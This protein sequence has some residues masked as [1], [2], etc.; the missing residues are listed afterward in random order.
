[1][2]DSSRNSGSALGRGAGVWLAVGAFA[3]VFVLWQWS[4]S[5]AILYP[6]RLL[7][8]FVHEAGHGLAAIVSG[9]RF[10]EFTV[11]PTGAGVALTAGGNPWLVLPAGYLGAALFGAILLYTANRVEDERWVTVFVG[12]FFVAVALIFTGEARGPVLI[13]C[14]VAAVLWGIAS[15]LNG[16]NATRLRIAAA[17][18]ALITLVLVFRTTALLVGLVSG[19]VLFALGVYASRAV[20]LFFLNTL[21][22][23]VGFNAVSDVASLWNNRFATLGSTANDALAFARYTNT[24]VEIWIVLWTL[25]ALGM[26]LTAAYFA[27]WRRR[28]P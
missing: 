17:V 14:L 6:F 2:T 23:I 8:T 27:F 7:V 19:V 10:I 15:Q 18:A 9:G 3:L 26:M 24:P 1:M 11:Y 13:S 4:G 20:T 16:Q 12:G 28:S 5:A 22:F 25:L 21:A